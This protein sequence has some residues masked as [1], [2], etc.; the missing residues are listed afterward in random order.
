MWPSKQK[1][2]K[3]TTSGLDED[4]I[5]VQYNSYSTEMLQQDIEIMCSVSMFSGNVR[6]SQPWT[7]PPTELAC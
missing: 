4:V 6:F 3:T 7:L 2:K 5:D 1:G